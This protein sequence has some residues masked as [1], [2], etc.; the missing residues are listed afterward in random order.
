M[1]SFYLSFMK[2]NFNSLI[3]RFCQDVFMTD[4]QT[5][6]QMVDTEIGS[7]SQYTPRML[8]AAIDALFLY[9]FVEE[10]DS[11]FE[12]QGRNRPAFVHQ[13]MTEFLAHLSNRGAGGD[14]AGGDEAGGGEAGGGEAEVGRAGGGEAEV[15]EAGGG[16]AEVGGAGGGRV[17]GGGAGGARV[18]SSGAGSGSGRVGGSG[19]G[20]GRV[21]GAE[22]GYGSCSID[23]DVPLAQR[24]PVRLTRA[25]SSPAKFVQA[26]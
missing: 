6:I 23:I 22:A 18:G 17:G 14:E 16:E 4:R 21:G 24:T 25:F 10:T 5:C 20:G 15:G 11:S 3:T 9:N 7:F 13:L 8:N 26:F 19:A 12:E 2:S 1:I